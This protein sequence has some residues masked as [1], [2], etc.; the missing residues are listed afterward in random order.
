MNLTQPA[1]SGHFDGKHVIRLAQ[2]LGAGLINPAIAPCGLHDHLPLRHCQ[3]GRLLTIDILARPHCQGRSQCVPAVA[4]GNQH[5]IHIHPL[6]QELA[7]IAVHSTIFIAL[8]TVHHVLGRFA[9]AFQD[10]TDGDPLH[11][12]FIQHGAQIIGTAAADSDS[13]HHD[14]FA[15]RHGSVT[16]QR[17]GRDIVRQR[18]RACRH[19]PTG[20]EP[21]PRE[22]STIGIAHRVFPFPFSLVVFIEFTEGGIGIC[23]VT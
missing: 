8:F 22:C 20:Q 14:A 12:P 17:R 11:I 18:H 16:P 15:G 3:T 9:P 13:S 2:P 19:G 7:H 10:I 5:G 23:T 4:G 21:A 6:G 1:G